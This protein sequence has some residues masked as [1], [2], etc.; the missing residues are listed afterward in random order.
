MITIQEFNGKSYKVCNGTFYHL[1]TSDQV[2]NKLESLRLSGT[3]I[4]VSFGD[5]TTGKD[6]QEQFD[7]TGR[8]GRSTGP[9]KAPLLVYNKRSFGGHCLLT[10]R[11]VQIVTSAGKNLIW[12]HANYHIDKT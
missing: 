7:I 6:W 5:T 2:V 3:R 8:I 1:E 10:H 12:K 4:R 11:I 9:V